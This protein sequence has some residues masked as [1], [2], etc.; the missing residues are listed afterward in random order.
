M[1]IFKGKCAQRI[2]YQAR[3]ISVCHCRLQKAAG[4]SNADELFEGLQKKRGSS[5]VQYHFCFAQ[6][7]G[8]QKC[9]SSSGRA[10]H[11]KGGIPSSAYSFDTVAEHKKQGC[12]SAGQLACGN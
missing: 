4:S 2:A 5:A 6:K 9:G 1:A 3:A 7:R 11:K 10:S 8:P 12:R